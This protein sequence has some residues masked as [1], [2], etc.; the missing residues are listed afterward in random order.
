M[1][2][3]EPFKA[4]KAFHILFILVGFQKVLSEREQELKLYL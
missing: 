3:V 4:Y 1:F 2:V